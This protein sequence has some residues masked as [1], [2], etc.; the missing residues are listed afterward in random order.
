MNITFENGKVS[1]GTNV[2]RA[3]TKNSGSQIKETNTKGVFALDISGTVMDN[4]AYEGQGKTAEDVMQDAGQIDVATQKNYMAVMSN[5]MSDEDFAKLQEQGFCPGSEEIETV[6]TIVDEIKAALV[7]GGNNIAGYTDDLDVD[8]LTQITGSAGFA[9]ELI[10]QFHKNDIPVTKENVEAVLKACEAAMQLEDLNDGVKKYMIRNHMEPTVDNIYK[11]QY[12]ARMDAGKQGKGY[13]QDDIGY[14]AKKAEEFNWQQLTPQMEKVIRN[15]GLE[16]SEETLSDAKWLVEKGIPLTEEA[17]TSLHELRN[18]KMPETMEQVISAAAAAVASGKSAGNANLS[19]DKSDMEKAQDYIDDVNMITDEAVDKAAAEG[20]TLNLRNLKAAQLQISVSVR[21]ETYLVHASGRR[22]LE[23]V[24]LRMSMQANLHL[25]RNGFSIDTAELTQL[26]DALKAAESRR[27]E[28]LFGTGS[29]EN[30]AERASLYKETLAKAGELPYMPAALVGKFAF[31]SVF[32]MNITAVS[33]SFTLSAVYEQGSLLRSTYEKAGESYE[34]LMTSPRSDLGD[35]IKKA[36]RNVD[37]ILQNLD[38]EPTDSNRRA[39]RILGYNR[40]EISE[41][42]ISAVKSTDLTIRRVVEKLTP[43]STLQMIRDGVNPLSMNMEE[44]ETYLDNQEQESG[45]DIEKYSEFLYKLDKNN[46]IT[47]EE[48]EAYIGIY[49]LFRQL[50]KTDSAAIGAL[51]NQGAEP[52]VAN[53]L[54]A[55]RSSRKQG[56]DITVDDSFGG[57]TSSYQGK[58]I[59]Q[60]IESGYKTDYF[61]KLTS[62]IFD[63][64]DGGIV[65]SQ[66]TDG[67]LNLEELA[68]MLRMAEE[69]NRAEEERHHAHREYHKEQLSQLREVFTSEESALKELLEFDQPVS[70]DNLLAAGLLSKERGRLSGRMKE[71]ASETGKEQEFN[72]AISN[73]QEKLTDEASAKEAY[74]KLQQTFTD[75]VEEA[76]YGRDG[77]GRIDIKEINN[78]YKQISL[79]GNL[80]RE[81]NYEIPVA[82]NGEVTAVNLRIVHNQKE[83]GM[84]SVVMQSLSYGK[85]MARFHLT[86]QNTAEDTRVIM[87]ASVSYQMSG[88][89]VSDSRKGLDILSRSGEVLRKGFQDSDIYTVSLNFIYNSELDLSAPVQNASFN[90]DIASD[91]IND[92]AGEVSTKKLYET[93]KTFISYIQK[94]EGY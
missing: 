3:T 58:S 14:Y 78:L 24:R 33:E 28:V 20:K 49:R 73:L 26:V 9:N 6:V 61:A 69:N 22:Q 50:D 88:Y 89:I 46:S 43:A 55:M 11:A 10:K 35:S 85:V 74:S 76:V 21:T 8:T 2:D 45:A 23:E 40:M 67:S 15:T 57:I 60:Q 90:K 83:S 53:L 39:V 18:L 34:A 44:L 27:E 70:A 75:I 63:H 48:R 86:K 54:S 66:M 65:T 62:D 47:Q 68:A 71:L 91:H 93:A 87:G 51:L 56:M 72:E 29:S 1:A 7:K 59:S 41:E 37:D 77:D 31:S 52:T 30:M 80:A 81:E 4:T 42:N 16:V 19:D 94:G 13:Y 25:L 17:L 92:G 32:R 64:L 82:I 84:V 12:S 79:T 38:L 5:T 36:F